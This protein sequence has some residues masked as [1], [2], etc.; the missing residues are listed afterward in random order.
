MVAE[1]TYHNMKYIISYASN[2][3][4]TY[5]NTIDKDTRRDEDQGMQQKEMHKKKKDKIYL[6][7]DLQSSNNDHN[8]GSGH[9]QKYL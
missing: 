2:I 5:H 3:N 1:G 6:N 9:H 7:M 4:I 8:K